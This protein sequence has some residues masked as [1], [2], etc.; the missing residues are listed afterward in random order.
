MLLENFFLLL[1]RQEPYVALV[2]FAIPFNEC[3]PHSV[4]SCRVSF[5]AHNFFTAVTR[6]PLYRLT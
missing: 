4:V 2:L 6:D 3:L 5:E 1:W